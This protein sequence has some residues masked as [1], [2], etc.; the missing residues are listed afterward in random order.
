[1][2]NQSM[3]SPSSGN[4]VLIYNLPPRMREVEFI[5]MIDTFGHIDTV[6]F[7]NNRDE[8]HGLVVFR[9]IEGSEQALLLDRKILDG[10]TLRVIPGKVQHFG[11]TLEDVM[12]IQHNETYKIRLLNFIQATLLSITKIGYKFIHSVGKTSSAIGVATIAVLLGRFH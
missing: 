9:N 1:M 10:K 7:T 4:T 2:L 12:L 6:G 5:E 8:S 3:F 11:L